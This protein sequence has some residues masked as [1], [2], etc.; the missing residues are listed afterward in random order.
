[1]AWRIGE[2]LVRKKLITWEQLEEALAEQSV[3]HK[4]TGQIL[5]DKGYVTP[6]LF[7][8]ALAEQYELKFVD[9]R[10]TRINPKAQEMI[11]QEM[12]EKFQI[13]GLECTPTTLIVGI[14]NPITNVPEAEIKQLT[15]R[16]EVQKVLCLRTQFEEVYEAFYL[17]SR[18]E[19]AAR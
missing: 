1:M 19:L 9:L 17:K 15:G 8:M 3:S 16:L 11:P 4:M 10:R 6:T 5:I 12:A 7:Q 18:P 14:Y 2:I 13:I